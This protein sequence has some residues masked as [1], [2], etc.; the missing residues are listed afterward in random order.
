MPRGHTAGQQSLR[1]ILH[2]TKAREL[3]TRRSDGYLLAAKS[4]L[5]P[6]NAQ[7]MAETHDAFEE[8]ERERKRE[9]ET[10]SED[11][12][13]EEREGGREREGA[14]EKEET[15]SIARSCVCAHVC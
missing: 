14:T 2:G 7:L 10:E 12:E 8:R 1:A 9:R 11:G 5:L 15:M 13:K 4:P 6:S 3:P